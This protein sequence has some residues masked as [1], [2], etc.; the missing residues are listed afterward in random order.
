MYFRDCTT[1]RAT[2]MGLPMNIWMN[3]RACWKDVRMLRVARPQ[4]V[5]EVTQRKRELT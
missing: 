1:T 2:I 5:I 3:I 4:T